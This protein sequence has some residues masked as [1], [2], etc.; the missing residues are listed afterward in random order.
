[1]INLDPISEY[2]YTQEIELSEKDR[3]FLQK[4]I[5][6]GKDN[7]KI[8]IVV[9]SNGKFKLHATQY[10]G[11]VK[12][13]NYTI[14]VK[15]KIGNLN[16]FKML[17]YSE[18]LSELNLLN[19]VR[20]EEGKALVDFMA[21]LFLKSIALIVQEGIYKN[22][23]S[24]TEEIPTIRGKLLIVNNIRKSR[25]SQEKFWCEYDELTADI[26]ENQILLY[27]C[28]L[29]SELV[30]DS[31]IKEELIHT[32]HTLQK[33]GISD[34]F[35]DSYHLDQII[36]Q[37]FNEHYE[38]V[39]KLCEF[40]LNITW[41]GDF[42]NK[43]KIPISGFLYNMNTLFQNFVT[44]ALK[45]KLE[46]FEVKREPKDSRLL[47]NITKILENEEIVKSGIL[48]PDIVIRN[49][50]DKKDAKLV[51]DT[52][53]KNHDPTPNDYYQ[54]V[55]YSLILNCPVLLLL[56]QQDKKKKG[57]FVLTQEMYKENVS[58]VVRTIDLSSS[59]ERD[60]VE[61]IKNRLKEIVNPMLEINF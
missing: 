54:S 39:L 9:L 40:I 27:C 20:I 43:D 25:I 58:I 11:T 57:D 45:E 48:K 29:L 12:I 36:Y 18:D 53:Y 47:N 32:Q 23:N 33:E 21:K 1:M 38:T 44:K 56:P 22:Y 60:Y 13:P 51:I 35:L 6:D 42:S 46:Q 34:V 52:K 37:K 14:T 19:N 17:V 26:L 49:K 3:E 8:E 31:S 50:Y 4:I 55:A 16:F 59:P 24:I 41:Y 15:P 10:V 61:L 28:Q 5:N 30:V 7:S 2:E